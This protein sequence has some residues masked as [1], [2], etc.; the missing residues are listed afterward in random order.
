MNQTDTEFPKSYDYNKVEKIIY[1]YWQEKHLFSPNVDDDKDPFT[2]I[3]PPPNVTGTLHYGHALTTAIEDALIRWNRMKGK[4]TL[5]LPGSDHAGIATQVVV[6]KMLMETQGL[7]RHEIGREKF[8]E[9][10]WEWVEKYGGIIDEQ[11]NSLGA[12]CD[13]S[14]KSFTLDE[15]PSLAVRTTFVNL[16]NKGK[17]YRGEKIINWCPRC[18]TSLSDLEVKHTEEKGDLFYIKYNIVGSNETLTV[19]TTRPETLFGDTAVAVNPLDERYSHLLQSKITIPLI[20]REVTI[21]SDDAVELGFGTGALKVTPA[22]DINDFE[23]GLRHEL[24]TIN[25]MNPDGTLNEFSG[26][27][28][29]KDRMVVRGESVTELQSLNLLEKI[30]PIVHSIGRCD[31]CDTIVEPLI[32]KQWF[33][34]MKPLAEPA[35]EAVNNG[36]IQIIPERFSKIYLNWMNNIRDWCISRQLWWGHRIPVWYC[37]FCDDMTASITDLETCSSCKSIDIYQDSDV[38]DT[39]FSSGLWTHSTLGWPNAT[40]DLNKYY[41]TS[42]METGYD[43][44][45]FWV[46]R[47]IM[48]GIENMGVSPFHT[49]YLH[50]LLRDE[51][52]AKMS[53]SKGNVLDPLDAIQKYGADALR[54]ALT[55]GSTPGNDVRISENKLESGRNF[56]NKL[57]NSCRFIN[58]LYSKTDTKTNLQI[59]E[60]KLNIEDIWILSRLN[61]L[62]EDVNKLLEDYQLGEAERILHDYIWSDFCDWYIEMAKVRFTEGDKEIVS[63]LIYIMDILLRLLHPFMPFITEELWHRIHFM[64]SSNTNIQSIMI[65]EYP[66]S[67]IKIVGDDSKINI[68][69]ELIRGIRNVRSEFNIQGNE[70]L[71]IYL[72]TTNSN[73]LEIIDLE[74]SF[75]KNS[76]KINDI[77]FTQV[78]DNDLSKSAKFVVADIIVTIPLTGLINMEKEIERLK[79]ELLEVD[80]NINRL[81]NLLKSENFVNKAP[82]EVVESEQERLSQSQERK[83]QLEEILKSIT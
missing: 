7:S 34:E 45:F 68:I 60:Q 59:D 36:D 14:R 1:S 17:I 27:Y 3:M 79:K 18:L 77:L 4:S 83:Y 67:S 33:L 12:S 44:L 5:W 80:S 29:G 73:S 61:I 48:F 75:I 74:K 22:H 16:Y 23:I 37:N 20:D 76:T 56:C 78:E 13:W 30:E 52:G 43:I 28:E 40:K 51:T 2:V 32:S 69:I 38:L 57:W 35:I 63:I 81:Q 70:D 8:L 26:K 54:F 42:V 15:G 65:S 62:I 39:W 58:F 10:V 21:I 64:K 72:S 11:F 9:H 66:K 6:E 53:K 46:A 55:T 47:M 82:E 24:D 71:N 50:G 41:P 49:I 25:V 19:A 31:R